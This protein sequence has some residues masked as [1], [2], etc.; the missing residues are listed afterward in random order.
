MD[1]KKRGWTAA[2]IVKS[3]LSKS[4]HNWN[5][6][7]VPHYV[8]R[9]GKRG[10]KPLNEGN[11]VNYPIIEVEPPTGRKGNPN[12]AKEY[13]LNYDMLAKH[14]FEVMRS[15]LK[16][17][18]KRK[19]KGDEWVSKRGEALKLEKKCLQKELKRLEKLIDKIDH[20]ADITDN[21]YKFWLG[22]P[23]D[24]AFM[25]LEENYNEFLDWNYVDPA[26]RIGENK[27]VLKRRKGLI[28]ESWEIEQKI[29]E[30]ERIEE[31]EE[32]KRIGLIVSSPEQ[33]FIE[34]PPNCLKFVIR[35]YLRYLNRV[36]DHTIEEV[37]L[38]LAKNLADNHFGLNQSMEI[39]KLGR[40]PTKLFG[41][42]TFCWDFD[43]NTPYIDF[44]YDPDLVKRG[45]N[46]T[47]RL[48]LVLKEIEERRKSISKENKNNPDIK[49]EGGQGEKLSPKV[50]KLSNAPA[51]I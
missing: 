5:N 36:S 22:V 38:S 2:D 15:V 39:Q 32:L 7:I 40:M 31:E 29:L 3:G 12:N 4:I 19:T 49:T 14:F 20:Q 50:S 9:Y 21:L 47:R 48:L 34:S 44:E 30:L 13:A 23:D 33:P 25:V 18:L 46:I 27:L 17:S 11:P 26:I 51:G 35:H 37:L 28:K 42:M 45:R 10:G 41:T 6:C 24:E 8:Y 1:T 16:K 43:Q